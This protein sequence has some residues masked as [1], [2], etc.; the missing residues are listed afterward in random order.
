[1][2]EELLALRYRQLFQQISV[3]DQ[4]MWIG[5]A[6]TPNERWSYFKRLNEQ[7]TV[8]VALFSPQDLA[9]QVANPSEGTLKQFF[10][11]H[12]REYASPYSPKP[13]FR[14]PRKVDVQYLEGDEEKFRSMVTEAEITQRY[15]KDPQKYARDKEEFEKQEKEEKAEAEKE[16]AAAKAAAEKKPEKQTEKKTETAPKPEAEKKPEAEEDGG[17][18]QETG[19]REEVG[20]P[21][22]AGRPEEVGIAQAPA[23][24]AKPAS[25]AKTS[26][27]A[28]AAPAA[29]KP[30]TSTQL[31][32]SPFRLVALT[33]DKPAEKTDKANGEQKSPAA[34]AAKST[35]EKKPADDKKP[36][37][38][39]KPS[40]QK[41]PADDK[42]SSDQKKP[43]DEKK[44]GDQKKP[45]AVKKAAEEKK[46]ETKPAA[47]DSA[48]KAARTRRRRFR[49]SRLPSNGFAIKSA[50]KLPTRRCKT[51]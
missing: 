45:E 49:R 29:K 32:R 39:K 13:G 51:T 23:A 2:R 18:R 30:D 14:V 34:S 9:K 37:G 44:P 12:K 1:M 21:K 43:A 6:A 40:D 38:D 22:E 24:D 7:A 11:D 20:R 10:E 17:N 26:E 16:A 47:A 35:D 25:D 8:E 41:K 50:T 31:H 33:E 46:P 19:T 48:R 42:K 3:T 27:P 5:G 15:E 36:A 4:N 28:K